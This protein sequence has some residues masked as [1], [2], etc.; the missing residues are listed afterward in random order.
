M[1]R[2]VNKA[3]AAWLLWIQHFYDK[4]LEHIE[5]V[6]RE[7]AEEAAKPKAVTKIVTASEF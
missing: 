4:G 7:E 1:V 5:D 3:C 6:K 2:P